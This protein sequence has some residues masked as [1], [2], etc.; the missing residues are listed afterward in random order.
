MASRGVAASMDDPAVGEELLRILT[1]LPIDTAKN[2][3]V[4][5]LG[6][7]LELDLKDFDHLPRAQR[8]ALLRL[9]A[10]LPGA[11]G[12][13]DAAVSSSE[14][15]SD[16]LS[17]R[18]L[19]QRQLQLLSSAPLGERAPP[20]L[21]R[22][23]QLPN[24]EQLP[25]PLQLLSIAPLGD[26]PTSSSALHAGGDRGAASDS[27]SWRGSL[28]PGLLFYAPTTT[29]IFEQVKGS[30]VTSGE[31][32]HNGGLNCGYEKSGRS[33]NRRAVDNKEDVRSIRLYCSRKGGPSHGKKH[34]QR[35]GVVEACNCPFYSLLTV[36]F[37]PRAYGP[38][39]KHENAAVNVGKLAALVQGKLVQREQLQSFL[40]KLTAEGLEEGQVSA[41][42]SL[43]EVHETLEMKTLELATAQVVLAAATEDLREATERGEQEENERA[44]PAVPQRTGLEK[45]MARVWGTQVIARV[46]APQR[47]HNHSPAD[48]NWVELSSASVYAQIFKLVPREVIFG[49]VKKLGVTATLDPMQIW[50]VLDIQLR[51]KLGG[52]PLPKELTDNMLKQARMESRGKFQAQQLL[53]Y[54]NQLE[55]DGGFYGFK[56]NSENQ[57]EYVWWQD[58]AMVQHGRKFGHLL[59]VDTTSATNR[60]KLP[61]LMATAVD[62]EGHNRLVFAAIMPNEAANSF[63]PAFADL[64]ERL[65]GMITCLV[66][67]SDLAIILSVK[68]VFGTA[69]THVLCIFH[70]F[71]NIR[72]NL[73]SKLGNSYHDFVRRFQLVRNAPSLEHFWKAF[74]RLKDEY[75]LA[76]EYL[77]KNLTT[78]AEKWASAYLLHVF[79]LGISSSQRAES[80]NR[81]AKHFGL[82]SKT[83]LQDVPLTLTKMMLESEQRFQTKTFRARARAENLANQEMV[84]SGPYGNVYTHFEKTLTVYSF[85]LVVEQL[86]LAVMYDVEGAEHVAG[87]VVEMERTQSARLEHD[88]NSGRLDTCGVSFDGE[89]ADNPQT[90]FD[91]VPG[92]LN[93]MDVVS[94]RMGE[95]N[96]PRL[97]VGD[98][99]AVAGCVLVNYRYSTK[100]CADAGA[101]PKQLVVFFKNGGY[102]CSCGWPARYGLVCRHFFAA[103]ASPAARGHPGLHG[104]V[105]CHPRWYRCDGEQFKLKEL[106]YQ[107][108]NHDG[109][110]D[111]LAAAVTAGVSLWR[112]SF[113]RGIDGVSIN[114]T[115]VDADPAHVVQTNPFEEQDGTAMTAMGYM[116]DMVG[117]LKHFG[118]NIL[119][120][121]QVVNDPLLRKIYDL[122]KQATARAASGQPSGIGPQPD[123]RVLDPHNNYR[124]K[125]RPRNAQGNCASARN[126]TTQSKAGPIATRGKGR[127]WTSDETSKLREAVRT[128]GPKRLDVLAAAVGSKTEEQCKTKMIRL[129][130]VGPAAVFGDDDR[131]DGGDDCSDG[132]DDRSGGGDKQFRSKYNN[133]LKPRLNT[134]GMEGNH[135]QDEADELDEESSSSDDDSA[136]HE[137]MPENFLDNETELVPGMIAAL[138]MGAELREDE[139]AAQ[140]RAVEAAMLDR[141]AQ[142]MA[143]PTNDDEDDLSRPSTPLELADQRERA[144][145]RV[146][147]DERATQRRAVEARERA[148]QREDEDEDERVAAEEEY[149][150]PKAAP[151]AKQPKAAPAAKQPKAA[152]TA[153]QPKAAPAAKPKA[154]AKRARSA[155]SSEPIPS[156]VA[157]STK[158]RRK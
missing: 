137:R 78:H 15:A 4:H 57:L 60:A 150:Q 61:L 154:T 147:E 105:H 94:D 30:V 116:C 122:I 56:L 74:A 2:L 151:A 44:R 51:D 66:T 153:K 86:R 10:K 104:G 37:L 121:N 128:Y 16:A 93:S 140:R 101:S 14:R 9:R 42:A 84:R 96:L 65:G 5:D 28:E 141:A 146:R 33:R 90:I 68:E 76:R 100:S 63:R 17:E 157:A 152:P 149:E 22:P 148:D 55:R 81:M 77:N 156:P 98:E 125:G 32:L 45:V 132:G 69:V 135:G 142:P 117:L 99:S 27:S 70:I 19:M 73:T 21:P 36:E 58:A 138:R 119:P 91:S 111:A 120:R 18:A 95:N 82:S 126:L 88:W 113:L 131:S 106:V 40:S 123:F 8:A 127:R 29:G 59:V 38:S 145:Q 31:S 23:L 75:P 46:E 25:L 85:G 64:K 107:H 7:L 53:D 80:I 133:K 108:R 6:D 72:K 112:A 20:P 144:E 92:G 130:A 143:P 110:G 115:C 134:L 155:D 52:M 39:L 71:D 47:P 34:T 158:R 118:Y 49:E 1:K 102:F 97:A 13:G 11:L 124:P 79:S 12:A 43:N 67:D 139:R 129:P 24:R 3:G 35:S 41:L 114:G 109:E 50:H 83:P 136:I 89:V 54:L 48:S 103:W 87:A 62:G 26:G